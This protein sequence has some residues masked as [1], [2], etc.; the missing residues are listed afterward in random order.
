VGSPHRDVVAG[1]LLAT[2]TR[3]GADGHSVFAVA[4]RPGSLHL[5]AGY[6][7]GGLCRWDGE[8]GRLM[9]SP[10]KREASSVLAVAYSSD[11]TKLAV[12]TAE[13]SAWLLD[14]ATGRR[15]A[16]DLGAR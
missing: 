5:A 15:I 6:A 4:F 13:G 9:Q 3:R 1:A 11:G 8:R 16:A 12:G 14:V 2:L 10:G 7:P